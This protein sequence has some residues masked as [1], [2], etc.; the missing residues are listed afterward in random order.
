MTRLLVTGATG[1][2]GSAVLRQALAAGFQVYALTRTEKAA[3][4]LT[5]LGAMPVVGDLSI[6]GPWQE[7][8]NASEAVIHLAQPETYGARVT[9]KRAEHFR[10]QRLQMDAHLFQS[11]RPE[12]IRRIVYVGGTSYFGD[13]G[14]EL[15]TEK[16]QPNPKGWGPYI[17]AAIE[18][19]RDFA[20]RGLPI[21]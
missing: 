5:S 15:R 2:I 4:R 13:Q 20:H 1:Y 16:T 10:D 12:T 9:K 6:P 3:A 19:L 21:I 17:A 18:A 11:L 8:A 14:T 7:E